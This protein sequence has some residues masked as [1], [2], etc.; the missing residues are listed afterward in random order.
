MGEIALEHLREQDIRILVRHPNPERR[1][2]A[3]LRICRSVRSDQLSESEKTLAYDLLQFMAQDA[4]GMVRRAMAVT[5]KNSTELPR[6]VA[7]KLAEDL[8]DIALPILEN[9][10]VFTDDDLIEILKSRGAAKVLAVAKR[11]VVSGNLVKAIVRY[12]D[13]RAIATMAANDG[14]IIDEDTA[15]EIIDF[16]YQDD[17]IKDAMI[18]RSDLPEKIMEKLITL[19]AEEAAVALNKK[20]KIE[21]LTAVD[22]AGNARERATIE[23]TSGDQTEKELRSFSTH[24]LQMGRLT[25]SFLVRAIGL[26]RISVVKHGLAVLA[27]INA[28]KAELMLFDTGPMGIRALC[29]KAGLDGLT[30]QLL[31]AGFS[32]YRDL[33]ISGINYDAEYFQQLML[34]RIL[35]LPF[36]LEK[37]DRDWLSERLDAGEKLAA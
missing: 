29:Q 28:A 23:L 1:A 34:E 25:P 3:A 19:A 7:L 24:L 9:S 14:A 22:I 6:I 37:S 13:S 21:A 4:V 18:S 5:L 17:L 35:T 33:E 27:G 15:E 20:H 8:D 30:T 36:E 12:G 2:N 10:P 31:R 16:Y 26:G 11:P 32:I